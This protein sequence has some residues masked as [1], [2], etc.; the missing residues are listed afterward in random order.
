MFQR[1]TA[2]AAGGNTRIAGVAVV[3][4]VAVRTQIVCLSAC[5]PAILVEADRDE[6]VGSRVEI[7]GIG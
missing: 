6:I 5:R 4:D 2:T 3:E 7:E 1:N